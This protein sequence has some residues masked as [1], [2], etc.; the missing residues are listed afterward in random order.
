VGWQSDTG[1]YDYGSGNIAGTS[2][3]YNP[4][5]VKYNSSGIAQ[6]AKTI[7]A[8]TDNAHY[9]GVAVDSGGNVYA[10]GQQGVTGNYDYGSGNIAGTGWW[11]NPVLVKY[12]STGTTKWAKTISAGTNYAS[13]RDVAVDSSG[14]VYAVGWQSETG[15]YDYGSGN[16]AGTADTNPVLI[17]YDPT[18]T[19]E[20]V[21]T[22]TAGTIYAQYNGVVVDSNG[23]VYAVGRQD[24]TE[25]YDYR[26][27]KTAAGTSKGFNPVLVK[28][29][30]GY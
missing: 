11:Y 29:G 6:W 26:D 18:G 17:K 10:V 7:S 5:L 16:I 20:F 1:V 27:G 21:K 4:V 23:N 24:G 2:I 3:V 14:N 9:Y 12:D 25:T 15:V 30:Y 19:V 8:G 22:I 28:Y 13:Y